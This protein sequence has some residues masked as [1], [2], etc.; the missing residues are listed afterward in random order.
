MISIRKGFTTCHFSAVPVA[1]WNPALQLLL[2][3]ETD[4]ICIRIR[5]IRC[6]DTTSSRCACSKSKK[7]VDREIPGTICYEPSKLVHFHHFQYVWTKVRYINL[8]Y[9]YNIHIYISSL[10]IYIDTYIYISIYIYVGSRSFSEGV[11]RKPHHVRP[12]TC[13]QRKTEKGCII[14]SLLAFYMR[15]TVY[16]DMYTLIRFGYTH[17]HSDI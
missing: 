6:L 8:I 7:G 12:E 16:I 10:Y 15:Y 1:V 11:L 13:P 14:Y 9:I 2:R 5:F 17:I 4:L 3:R